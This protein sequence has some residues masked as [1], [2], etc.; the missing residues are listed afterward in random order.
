MDRELHGAE[1]GRRPRLI[2]IAAVG[3]LHVAEGHKD[4]VRSSFEALPEQADVLLL[5]GD[6]TQH[7][8]AAEGRCLA[9]GL[10]DLSVP[11]VAVLGNHDYHRGYEETIRADLEAV[12]VVVL[13]GEATVLRL[14]GGVRLGIA[15][16]KGFGGGFSGACA[17][18]FGEPEMKTFIRHT[19]LTA[20]RLRDAL[21]GLDANLRVV[22]THY[23]PV[24]DTLEGE[25][26][27]IY[28]FLGSYLL[29]EAIDAAPCDLAVHG[30]A[31]HGQERGTTPG[32]VPV[33]NVARP[34]IRHSFKVYHLE[35]ARAHTLAASAF[36][37]A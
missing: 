29:G 37:E 27:Q 17:S 20:R 14:H 22:L 24:A 35:A 36:D 3:D 30:H 12:G 9:E 31:H 2:R 8:L 34:V 21:G 1:R 18:E 11:V 26:L 16:T 28:P 13:E 7:G 5:A 19:K 25:K 15:G 4:N 6:L 10:R 23:S 32:G 33:R